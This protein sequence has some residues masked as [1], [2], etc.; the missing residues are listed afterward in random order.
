MKADGSCDIVV[1]RL[2]ATGTGITGSLK[3]GGAGLDGVNIEDIQQSGNY[4]NHTTLI[5]NYGDDSRSE[6]ILDG[7]GIIYVAGQT[8][9]GRLSNQRWRF[10][11]NSGWLAGRCCIEDR[12][13]L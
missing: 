8:Q 9:S 1:T 11:V 5:R 2:N 12:P 7:A 10:S 4:D 6:V 3:I 13:K